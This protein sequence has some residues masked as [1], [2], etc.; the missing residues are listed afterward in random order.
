VWDISFIVLDEIKGY[1]ELNTQYNAQFHLFF[2]MT[3]A[4]YYQPALYRGL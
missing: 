1:F 3:E 2:P 4:D